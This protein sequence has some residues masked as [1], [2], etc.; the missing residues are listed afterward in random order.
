MKNGVYQQTLF[1]N[2]YRPFAGYR[3]RRR[4]ERFF[5]D[6]SQREKNSRLDKL[7]IKVVVDSCTTS[8]HIRHLLNSYGFHGVSGALSIDREWRFEDVRREDDPDLNE[9]LAFFDAE[10][11]EH[12]REFHSTSSDRGTKVIFVVGTIIDYT[13]RAARSFA[14]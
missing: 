8:Y 7:V 2:L 6:L 12:Q 10:E 1:L 3:T 4:V 13:P 11:S 14:A 9:A 5:R